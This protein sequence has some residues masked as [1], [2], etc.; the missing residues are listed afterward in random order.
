MKFLRYGARNY[1]TALGTTV[2]MFVIAIYFAVSL[3]PVGVFLA[4]TFTDFG[5]GIYG[6]SY[7]WVMAILLFGASALVHMFI[8]DARMGKFMDGQEAFVRLRQAINTD[9]EMAWAYYCNFAVAAYSEG[10]SSADSRALAHRY[11]WS[12]FGFDSS[13]FGVYPPAEQTRNTTP[14]AGVPM[15]PG[16]DM[17][18]HTSQYWSKPLK[19]I[20]GEY[21]KAP[22]K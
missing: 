12:M 18:T 11:M 20:E 14:A 10:Y 4:E 21:I 2:I 6:G 3:R 9:M 15:H 5:G 17:L 1:L 7:T 19:D 13:R 22:R 16:Y 8:R